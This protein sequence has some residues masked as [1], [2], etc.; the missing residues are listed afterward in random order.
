MQISK[1]SALHYFNMK[2]KCCVSCR[3]VYAF[4]VYSRFLYPESLEICPY[5]TDQKGDCR[6]LLSGT[7]SEKQ[8][9]VFH[10]P[11]AMK[12]SVITKNLYNVFK[13]AEDN[14]R[15]FNR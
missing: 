2:N 11:F 9:P 13:K 15:S 7:F 14:L 4:N 12:N 6:P 8:M 3:N 1:I 5:V 10:V